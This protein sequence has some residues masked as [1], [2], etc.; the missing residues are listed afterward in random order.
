[1]EKNN[2]KLDSKFK[3]TLNEKD[4]KQWTDFCKKYSGELLINMIIS[5][6][7]WKERRSDTHESP[8]VTTIYKLK[9]SKEIW[10]MTDQKFYQLKRLYKHFVDF[11]YQNKDEIQDLISDSDYEKRKE[12]LKNQEGFNYKKLSKWESYM[13]KDSS[14]NARQY[15][16]KLKSFYRIFTVQELV[17]IFNLFFEWASMIHQL[18]SWELTKPENESSFEM[19]KKILDDKVK[20]TVND[21]SDANIGL[22]NSLF[23]KYLLYLKT[24]KKIA[25][26]LSVDMDWINDL[27]QQWQQNL[28]DLFDDDLYKLTWEPEEYRGEVL[29]D[30]IDW[31]V[32]API[33]NYGTN[34]TDKI[35]I[36]DD[37]E[38]FEKPA[39]SASIWKKK[40]KKKD[41]PNQLNLLN[42]HN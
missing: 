23:S 12:Q 35:E 30:I 18:T 29:M 6:I 11:Y 15:L 28:S 19:V 3:E 27:K 14:E 38:K 5:W 25:S 21:I 39:K 24:N 32:K 26:T 1:M 8:E 2:S 37:Y 13:E 20:K 33:N 16:N 22:I 4:K 31:E 7:S 41:D 42:N 10:W 36:D 17:Q 40:R 34:Y 9:N